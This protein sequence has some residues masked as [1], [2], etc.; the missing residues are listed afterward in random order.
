M[1]LRFTRKAG[2]AALL[3]AASAF[4]MMAGSRKQEFDAVV[5]S[6]DD[7]HQT[8]Q[9]NRSFTTSDTTYNGYSTATTTY[10]G[11][12]STYNYGSTTTYNTLGTAQTKV[13]TYGT[14]NTNR[15]THVISGNQDIVGHRLVLQIPDGRLVTVSC[16]SKYAPHDDYVNRRSCRVPLVSRVR[17]EIW[18]DNA[19]MYWSTS[20]DDSK[21]QSETYK[22]V[23]VLPAPQAP[24]Q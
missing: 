11:T 18:K 1:T 6:V 2:F 23:G 15:S 5:I 10:K 8:V 17:V 21:I 13:N 4:N 22:I 9:T 20:L 19:K 14:A 7:H 3:L 12:T 24:A 16:A